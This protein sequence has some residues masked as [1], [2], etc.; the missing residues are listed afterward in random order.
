MISAAM[1][2]PRIR[3]LQLAALLALA[4]LFMLRTAFLDQDLPPWGIAGYQPIDEGSYSIL[5]LNM[6]NYGK[7]NLDGPEM[8]YPAYTPPHVRVNLVGNALSYASM[9]LFGKNY[10]GYRLPSVMWAIGCLILVMLFI[11]EIDKVDGGNGNKKRWALLAAMFLMTVNFSFLCASRVVEPSVVRAFFNALLLY[12]MLRRR[13]SD[14]IRFAAMGS[15]S[16]A[17]VFLVYV[18]NAFIFL[19]C[20]ALILLP[21]VRR[22]AKAFRT[23]LFSFAIGAAAAFAIAE[24]YYRIVWGTSAIGNMVSALG[25]FSGTR[26][27]SNSSGIRGLVK[28]AVAFWS[29]NAFLY[30]PGLLCA[31]LAALFIN[32]H[33]IIHRKSEAAL[34][35]IATIAG[36]FL[37]TLYANEYIVRKIIAIFPI[38]IMNIVL[39]IYHFPEFYVD[40]RKGS[41]KSGA[42][43]EKL[44]L[45][46]MPLLFGSLIVGS[47]VFRVFIINDKTKLDFSAVDRYLILIVAS[48][49]AATVFLLF[50]FRFKKNDE[51]ATIRKWLPILF[52][53]FSLPMNAY[54]SIK[55]VFANHT[56]SEK[57]VMLDIAEYVNGQFVFGE[58]ENGFSLY[59]SMKPVLHT[60]DK[61]AGYFQEKGAEYYFDY[62]FQE[63]DAENFLDNVV[64]INGNVTVRQIRVFH[65]NFKTFGISRGVAL[66]RRHNK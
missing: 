33:A 14:R 15:I 40:T 13:D 32:L 49:V 20:A 2:N 50:A 12:T 59:N 44:R 30:D 63:K 11:R 47:A 54:F 62:S 26:G 24:T 39:A 10:F 41:Q 31:T 46:A 43:A 8:E 64:F 53:V 61:I 21:L 17:S 57:Q 45:V 5:A 27:Y 23:R 3:R 1:Q 60:Y 36:L 7:L 9:K 18:S 19:P 51:S 25:D 37:Q 38:L 22:D 58:Y 34:F 6:L 56:Y 48:M 65:R 28:N 16:V 42:G 55:Y 29:S 35:V 4:G 52:I 66:Y